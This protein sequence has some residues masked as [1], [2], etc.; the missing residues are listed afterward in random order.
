MGFDGMSGPISSKAYVKFLRHMGQVDPGK[1]YLD[2]FDK[3]YRAAKT[4]DSLDGGNRAQELIDQY[5][6]DAHRIGMGFMLESR[7]EELT[8]AIRKLL[9]GEQL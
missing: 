4:N 6:A 8:E 2:V 5:W 3:K 7:V 1:K 9:P